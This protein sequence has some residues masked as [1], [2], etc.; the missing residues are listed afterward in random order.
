MPT[1]HEATHRVGECRARKP[2]H[3]A[4]HRPPAQPRACTG[5]CILGTGGGSIANRS[6]DAEKGEPAEEGRAVAIRILR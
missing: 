6:A 3:D 2:V 5:T 1:S 4:G